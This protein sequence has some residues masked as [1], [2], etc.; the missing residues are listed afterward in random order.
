MD[1]E[2]RRFIIQRVSA[3]IT[4]QNFWEMLIELA[5]AQFPELCTN[6]DSHERMAEN[7]CVVLDEIDEALKG[8]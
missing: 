6:S 8:L 7:V 3:G 5:E 2:L 1:M 4:D